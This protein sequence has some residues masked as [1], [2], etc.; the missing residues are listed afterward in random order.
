MPKIIQLVGGEPGFEG[1][2]CDCSILAPNHGPGLP[3]G[4]GRRSELCRSE[5]KFRFSRVDCHD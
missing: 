4:G 1:K 2:Q 3:A 5:A